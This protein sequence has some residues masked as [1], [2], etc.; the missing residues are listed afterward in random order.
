MIIKFEEQLY[1]SLKSFLL[2]DSSSNE[3]ICYLLG[4][5]STKNGKVVVYP[6]KI[7][8][9]EES[10]VNATK[11]SIRVN[12]DIV[13]AIYR[14]F[15]ESDYDVIINCHSH[16]FDSSENVEFSFIDDKYD[17]I[18]ADYIYNEIVKIKS[19]NDLSSNILYSSIV[20]G[21]N[22]INSRWI[23]ST[24]L[25]KFKNTK[26]IDVIGKQFSILHT[27]I[28]NKKSLF[29]WSRQ[30]LTYSKQSQNTLDKIS[31]AVIGA[32]GTGSIIAEGLVRLGVTNI[33]I[34]DDDIVELTNL[35]RWQGGR[36]KDIGKYKSKALAKKLE[37]SA[38]NINVL[39]FTFNAISQD[40]LDVIKG[41]D[42]LFSC[43]DNAETR[44]FLNRISN[45]YL[46]PLFDTGVVLSKLEA[47]QN[48]AKWQNR[49]HIPGTTRCNDCSSI[50]IY[51]KDEMCRFF[52]DKTTLLN[53]KEQGYIKDEPNEKSPSVYH[54]NSFASS[55]TLYEFHNY[56]AGFKE[57]SWFTSGDLNQIS[58]IT[59]AVV[60]K[61]LSNFPIQSLNSSFIEDESKHCVNCNIYKG[62]GDFWSLN[63]F[64]TT[65]SKLTFEQ[66]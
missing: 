31:V 25:N 66:D 16:P 18:E 51:D 3:R 50:K 40:S 8:I 10:S 62:T 48:F 54:L 29:Q 38:E 1:E 58:N 59:K 5:S 19:V 45:R 24:N 12:K 4:H 15:G 6:A 34:I 11:S 13:G 53:M 22:S 57:L 55:L 56:L 42:I 2:G 23:E 21:Q 60:E 49:L 63:E 30:L 43:V 32:G 28:E 35:N 52:F 33:N 46:L 41:C 7:L 17:K 26:R 47:S 9:P 27:N 65:E 61:D 44:F 64:F 39:P 36:I 37:N 14:I 20:I